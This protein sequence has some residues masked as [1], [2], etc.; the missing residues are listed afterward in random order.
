MTSIAITPMEPGS[1]GV[2]V[3]EGDV[4]TSHRVHLSDGLVSDLQL[5]DVEPERIV[6]ESV[7]FLLDRV[8]ATSLPD[9]LSLDSIAGDHPDYYEEL[10]SRLA[11]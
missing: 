7:A 11:G 6:N 1:F 9:E 5:S 2:Q 8:P 4:T 3:E 10:R